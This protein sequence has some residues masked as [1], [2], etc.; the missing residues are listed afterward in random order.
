MLTRNPG[1]E[2]ELEAVFHFKEE[3]I[4]SRK[5][6]GRTQFLGSEAP[7]HARRSRDKENCGEATPGARQCGGIRAPNKSAGV[8]GQFSAIFWPYPPAVWPPPRIY[9]RNFPAYG[10]IFVLKAV[11]RLGSTVGKFP[12]FK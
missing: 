8:Y 11:L 7:T 9:H 3:F 1:L 12:R 2:H 10:H 6:P 4:F 5:T